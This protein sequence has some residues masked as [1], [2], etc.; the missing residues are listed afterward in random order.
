MIS[1]TLLTACLTGGVTFIGIVLGW[2]FNI[3]RKNSEVIRE[4]SQVISAIQQQ[5]KDDNRFCDE[6]HI[7]VDDEI[8]SVKEELKE[9]KKQ[10]I[11]NKTQFFI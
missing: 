8:L 7:K 11:C 9:I 1:N 2:G 6:R 10:M 4:L 5:N 3:V